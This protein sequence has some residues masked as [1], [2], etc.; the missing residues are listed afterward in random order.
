MAPVPRRDEGTGPDDGRWRRLP[1]D[2]H[3]P[4][5]G[6]GRAGVDRTS[7]DGM[8]AQWERDSTVNG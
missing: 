7:F 4:E 6:P 3:R 5:P 8:R 1:P 2:D